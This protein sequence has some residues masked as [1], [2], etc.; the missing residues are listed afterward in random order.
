MRASWIKEDNSIIINAL[1]YQVSGS[2]ILEQIAKQMLAKKLPIISDLRDEGDELTPTRLVL[3]LKSKQVGCERLMGHLFKTTDLETSYRVHLN[4][5]GLDGRP[6]VHNLKTL[7]SDW[8]KFRKETILRRL[9]ARLDYITDR[10]EVLEG[11]IVVYLNLDEV[12]RIIRTEDEPKL[13]MMRNFDLTKRQVD[14]ILEI[15]L[16]QLAKLEEV[17]IR[18]EQIKLRDESDEL[19]STINTPRKL[20][21]LT[22]KEIQQVAKKYGDER[23]SPMQE[24]GEVRAFKA[25]EFAPVESITVFLSTNGWVRKGKGHSFDLSSINHKSGDEYLCH[26][27]GKSNET[28]IF[29]DNTGRVYTVKLRNLPSLRSFGDPLTKLLDP[30]TMTQFTGMILGKDKH[31]CLLSTNE[32]Y[33][34]LSSIKKMKSKFR[35]GK[36]VLSLNEATPL[37]LEL[38]SH[39]SQSVAVIT[40][41][42]RLLIFSVNQLPIQTKGKGVKLI[43]IPESS[44]QS[45]EFVQ[46]VKVFSDNQNLKI[47]SGKQFVRLKPSQRVKY[48]NYRNS[49]GKL[50]PTGFRRV[51]EVEI[52]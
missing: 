28:L 7:L 11:L 51:K 50:L 45:G 39:L 22:I 9:Q 37:P 19:Q 16:R 27:M 1:P 6:R 20:K 44:R 32:G 31:L 41:S 30:P 52:E 10:L 33:G 25:E 29:M 40:N 24:M 21:Q 34:F 35:T 5:I 18:E 8:L 14:A 46:F 42:G 13:V 2:K 3:D 47:Y 17:K 48:K 38:V 49:K 23:C 36:N 4:L 26:V 15:R 43:N 12:I